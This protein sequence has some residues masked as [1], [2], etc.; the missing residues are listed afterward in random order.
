[1]Q[2]RVMV[3]PS[4][5]IGASQALEVHA[6]SSATACSATTL[7]LS[8]AEAK[9]ILAGLQRHLAQA[10]AEEH[11]QLRRRCSRC[12]EWR[13]LKDRRSWQLRSLFGTV[14]VRAP[15]FEPC[16]CSVTLRTVLSQVTEIMPDRCTPEYECVLAELGA[17]LP[18]RRARALRVPSQEWLK[19]KGCSLR[20]SP[21][22]PG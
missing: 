19:F 15:R 9:L 11:C 2:W 5:A 14:E 20:L 1:M 6:G 17:L 3:G 13:P 4:G 21:A 18:Y 12:G 8:L 7:G 22:T 10:Q 16:R